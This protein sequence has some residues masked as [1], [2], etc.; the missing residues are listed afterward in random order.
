MRFL[1][2]ITCL[3][4]LNLLDLFLALALLEPGTE[5]NPLAVWL[6]G[7]HPAL[8]VAFKCLAV[9]TACVC[10]SVA[11]RFR[12]KLVLWVTWVLVW[13]LYIPMILYGAIL[14]QALTLTV[15]PF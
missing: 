7:V 15:N 2:A 6:W 3:I 5:S 10:L 11:Y 8:L 1:Q 4:L 13:V 14:W 12:P 9:G